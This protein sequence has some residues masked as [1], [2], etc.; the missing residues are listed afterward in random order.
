MQIYLNHLY[1]SL[2]HIPYTDVT[3]CFI[4][5]STCLHN[6]HASCFGSPNFRL[7][8]ECL[9]ICSFTTQHTLLVA[10]KY[11]GN[12]VMVFIYNQ[13]ARI[14]QQWKPMTGKQLNEVS[15]PGL[16]C[17]V[18]GTQTDCEFPRGGVT[19]EQREFHTGPGGAI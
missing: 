16:Q 18:R 14:I 5:L 7:G 12:N 4:K 9:Q 19:K 6:T 1:A 17:Q 15:F 2:R 3:W 8:C 13:K 10:S 11:F